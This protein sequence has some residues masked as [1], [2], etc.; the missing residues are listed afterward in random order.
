M[1]LPFPVDDDFPIK[2]IVVAHGL[3]I[4]S[5]QDENRDSYRESRV[6]RETHDAP[7]PQL[8]HRLEVHG[9][10]FHSERARLEVAERPDDPRR[11]QRLPGETD[12]K[13]L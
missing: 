3:S 1:A 9:L 4:Q 7:H 5:G 2:A 6:C 10:A 13:K 11:A 8:I 12:P